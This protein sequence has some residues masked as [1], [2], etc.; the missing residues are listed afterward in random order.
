MRSTK[1]S[2][3]I[4]IR[5]SKSWRSPCIPECAVIGSLTHCHSSPRLGTHTVA[6]GIG[7]QSLFL[8]SAVF[9]TNWVTTR[10]VWLF[11]TPRRSCL[12][13]G[14]VYSH[15][16]PLENNQVPASGE[17]YIPSVTRHPGCDPAEFPWPL[18]DC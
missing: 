3:H 10:R 7:F 5:Q 12:E 11:T 8:R 16:L 18:Y 2:S 17:Q 13:R 6:L 14:Y 9:C 1:Q 4:L 15:L